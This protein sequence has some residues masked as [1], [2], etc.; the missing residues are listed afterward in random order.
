ML[1][2]EGINKALDECLMDPAVLLLGQLVRHGHS[3]LTQNLE[4]THSS[5][6]VTFPVCESLM[7]AS[8]LGLALVGKRPV[9]LHERF[10]FAI[11]GMDALVNHIP[12][13]KRKCL[14]LPLVIMCVVGFGKG[15]GPQQD[16]DFTN[17]FKNLEGWRVCEPN[18]G[19]AAYMMLKQAIFGE[20][21]VMYVI[22]RELY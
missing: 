7:N 10:D 17:W 21:P 15:Q 8:A 16:K 20:D 13:W 2:S 18:T 5:Q 11:V 19:E 3:K 6:V 14:S 22:H 1:F 12:I 4:K 9:V